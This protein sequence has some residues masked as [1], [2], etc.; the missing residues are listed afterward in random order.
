MR[1][2]LLDKRLMVKNIVILCFI[3]HQICA[4][5][6]NNLPKSVKITRNSQASSELPH[7][8]GTATY[9]DVDAVMRSQGAPFFDVFVKIGKNFRDC[10]EKR[11]KGRRSTTGSGG[12]RVDVKRLKKELSE[13][14]T[15]GLVAYGCMNCL[16]YTIA[17][18]SFG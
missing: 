14:G 1:Y 3:L 7:R 10:V 5:V 13:A 12:G 17:T 15:G 8:L 6:P 11:L 18:F 4:F 16:Y 9:E 2:Y